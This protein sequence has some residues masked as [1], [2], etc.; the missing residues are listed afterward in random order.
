MCVVSYT[1]D[2]D[3]LQLDNIFC[4]DCLV[5]G[6]FPLKLIDNDRHQVL[7]VCILSYSYVSLSARFLTESLKQ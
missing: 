2:W 7:L 1:T 5:E 3:L 4:K 6:V